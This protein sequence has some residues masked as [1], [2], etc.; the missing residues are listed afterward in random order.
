M[1]N[2]HP[3]VCNLCGGHVI[4]TSNSIIYG[5]EYGSGQCYFCTSC[6]AYVGTHEPRPDEAF[7]IL[8]N[9]E[10]RNMKMK[11]HEI[12]DRFWKCGKNGKRRHYL[13]QST[14]KR[15][16]SDMN[17]SVSECHFGYFDL[18]QLKTA[19]EYIKNWGEGHE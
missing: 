17:I 19:Y 6:K 7:G 11:C 10:M 3:I 16:A 9:A 14:Y 13:R 4:L 5:R 15:L 1:I 8:A 18:E 2:L 12:F